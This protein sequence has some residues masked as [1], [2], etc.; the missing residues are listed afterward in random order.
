MRDE[1]EY[2]RSSLEILISEH[3]HISEAFK[4]ILYP[5]HLYDA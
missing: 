3:G 1:I 2:R 4:Y 5:R